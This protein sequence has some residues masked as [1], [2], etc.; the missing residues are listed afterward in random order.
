MTANAKYQIIAGT[1]YILS[2]DGKY[3]DIKLRNV[4]D[5]YVQYQRSLGMEVLFDN[6]VDLH[7]D[8]EGDDPLEA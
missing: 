3:I 4:F 2:Q 7:E 1:D 6:D 8:E 5:R